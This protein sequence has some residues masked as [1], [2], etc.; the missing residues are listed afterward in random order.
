[1]LSWRM[2]TKSEARVVVREEGECGMKKQPAIVT[3]VPLVCASV[4]GVC[5]GE[6]AEDSVSLP[7]SQAWVCFALQAAEANFHTQKA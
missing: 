3:D 4:C 6:A 7:S 5:G 1:M 2:F